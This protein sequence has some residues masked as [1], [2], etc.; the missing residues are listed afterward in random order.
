MMKGDDVGVGVMTSGVGVA[1][2]ISI[3]DAP[4]RALVAVLR[5]F[6]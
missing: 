2:S 5:V 6:G 3:T 1:A 4:I